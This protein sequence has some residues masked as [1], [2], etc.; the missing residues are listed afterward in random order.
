VILGP[1]IKDYDSGFI[2][3]KKGVLD[4]VP[5]PTKKGYG[6]YF[7]EFV[8]KCKKAGFKIKEIPYTFEDRKKGTSKTSA[9]LFGFLV[10]G[11]GYLKRIV[12]IRL[13]ASR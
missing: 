10:L 13:E 6:D 4:K 11:L 2:V 12:D 8:F 9:S 5:F 7:I 1:G 3:F